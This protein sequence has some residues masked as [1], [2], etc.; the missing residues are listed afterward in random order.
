MLITA[1]MGIWQLKDWGRKLAIILFVVNILILPWKHPYMAIEYSFNYYY[2][3][4]KL[5]G[6]MTGISFIKTINLISLSVMVICAWD[7][8]LNAALIF[9]FTRGKIKKQFLGGEKITTVD[10]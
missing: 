9:F 4:P 3:L 2:T 6:L 10:A 8:F 7:F 5:N 1:G